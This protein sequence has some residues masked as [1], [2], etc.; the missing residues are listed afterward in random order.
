[1]DRIVTG[2]GMKKVDGYT[3]NTIG[4]PSMVLMERAAMAICD[5]FAGNAEK[6][7]R[8]LCVCGMGNNGADGVALARQLV[9][10][11]YKADVITVGNEEK[12]TEEW[13]LQR[14]IAGNLGVSITSWE[15]L[16]QG[17]GT[18]DREKTYNEILADILET[19][20]YVVD[21]LFGIGLTRNVE[22]QFADIIQGINHARDIRESSGRSITVVAA[23]VPS[24][25]DADNGRIMGCAIKADVTITFGALKSGLLL[26]MGKDMA[27]KV[28]V[29]DIGF[30][31]S[32]YVHG[33]ER[34]EK[35]MTITDGD[36][37][38]VIKRPA[39][40]NK[41]TYGKVLVVAG[42]ENMY[43]AA[44]LS[45]MAALKTGCGLVRIITHKN[46]RE[47]LY[48]MIPEAV[49]QVYDNENQL[50]DTELKAAVS[51]SD[52]VIIGPGLGTARQAVKLVKNVMEITGDDEKYLV[53]DADGLNV[54]S[55]DD[56]LKEL[57]HE[58]I[59]ITPHPGEAAR[60]MKLPVKEIAEELVSLGRQYSCDNGINVVLKD[61]ATVILGIESLD[62]KCNNRVCI[63][64]SGN[65]GMA[66]A[67]SGDVLAGII[68]GVLA[69]G[70]D[71]TTLVEA[72]GRSEADRIF[73]AAAL[74][75][76]I[77]GKAGDLAADRCGQ[78]SMTATDILNMICEVL[79][80]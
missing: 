25:L 22:G 80:D 3:I 67:G 77:H 29:S 10:N 1:M 8:I 69:G 31:E 23:D 32:A 14:N 2:K 21:A 78:I 61:S 17:P 28:I 16:K 64:T 74:A 49:I 6:G 52:A 66:T 45:S 37:S 38:R 71:I 53:I 13:R 46:N 7:R 56:S 34:H 68:A 59:V 39:H 30:P 40:S 24:G 73:I 57:Y 42:S 4:I 58:K 15:S 55:A 75:V 76:F 27:G 5:Y 47:L 35:Y 33:P 11:G 70:M 79:A 20:D 50:T 60:L 9:A 41:G 65:A 12:A 62:N 26:Y 51:W 72:Y 36:V 44:Y 19:Y 43:G 18:E 63:N 48:K 54:I